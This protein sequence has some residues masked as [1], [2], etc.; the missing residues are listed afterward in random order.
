MRYIPEDNFIFKA[1]KQQDQSYQAIIY[2]ELGFSETSYIR[3]PGY[4]KA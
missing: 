2:P 3:Q 1:K 4:K